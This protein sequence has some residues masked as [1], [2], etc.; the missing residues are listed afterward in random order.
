MKAFIELQFPYCPFIWMFCQRC[1][2]NRINHLHERALRIVYN[3]NDSTFEDRLRK[4]VSVRHKNIS[5]LGIELYKA[6]NNL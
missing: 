3:D 1:L 4:T 2:N 5:L 6:K